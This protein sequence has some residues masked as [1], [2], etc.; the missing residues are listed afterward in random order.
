MRRAVITV[1]KLIIDQ[2]QWAGALTSATQWGVTHRHYGAPAETDEALWARVQDYYNASFRGRLLTAGDGLELLP[3]QAH[4]QLLDE[5]REAYEQGDGFV[6]PLVDFDRLVDLLTADGHPSAYV[7]QTGGGCATVY[8]GPQWQDGDGDERW[9]LAIG[10]GSFDGPGW[11]NGYGCT[12]ELYVSRDDDGLSTGTQIPPGALL[13]DI[14][15]ICKAEAA[16]ALATTAVEQE[17][18]RTKMDVLRREHILA[19]GLV[20][21]EGRPSELVEE[22]IGDQFEPDAVA[23]DF[24]WDEGGS[25]CLY[26]VKEATLCSGVVN[27]DGEQQGVLVPAG[28][29]LRFT[30]DKNSSCFLAPDEAAARLYIETHEALY[31]ASENI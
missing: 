12:E 10:P 3:E 30:K 19:A 23:G 31:K 6:R 14:V 28:N 7:E 25:I 24:E 13:T 8:V 1:D 18:R 27:G 20:S 21:Y 2:E 11:R 26:V 22:A 16:V 29:Y 9:T 17:A 15:K 4:P 5:A